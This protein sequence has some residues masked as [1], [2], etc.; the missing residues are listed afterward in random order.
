MEAMSFGDMAMRLGAALL[1]SGLV[2]LERERKRHPAG[3]RTL[4]LVGLGSAGFVIAGH[5]LIAGLPANNQTGAEMSRVIQG[6]V[7]GIGFL[8]AGSVIQSKGSVRGVTTAAS[9][10][11]TSCIGLASGMGIYTLAA[12]LSVF[13]VVTLALFTIVEDK[14]AP[15]EP[16]HD[17]HDRPHL[18]AREALLEKSGR[19]VRV[20]P[21]KA[22]GPVITAPG[23]G[24]GAGGVGAAKRGA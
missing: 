11:V 9:V 22:E 3:L 8:G 5:E 16:V 13:T 2:G 20:G 24:S 6:I 23:L 17:E 7:G 4:M 21:I 10:W 14:I 15:D 1:L 19:S 12:S 18:H